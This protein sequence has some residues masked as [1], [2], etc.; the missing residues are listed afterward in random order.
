MSAVADRHRPEAGR[1]A[2]AAGGL[3]FPFGERRPDAGTAM[4]V[5]PGVHWLR[6]PLPFR[7]DHINLWLLEDGDG[8]TLVDTG[9]QLDET[10]QHWRTLFDRFGIAHGGRPGRPATR[11]IVTHFHPD[12]IGLAGWLVG[13]LDTELWITRTE[14]LMARMLWL[15]SDAASHRSMADFYTRHGLAPDLADRLFAG[16]NTYRRRVA[17]TPVRHRRLR[18][19]DVLEIGGRRWEV[20]V[21][22][23]HAPEHACLWTVDGN[24][25]ISGDQILPGIT[26]NI[27]V[28]PNEPDASPL[29]DYLGSFARF[30]RLPD[31][32]L[33]LPSH[34][35]PF[36]GLQTRIGQI[37]DHHRERLERLAGAFEGERLSAADAV[38]LL[39]RRDLDTHQ[40]GFAL[41]EC[42]A[43]LAWLEGAGTLAGRLDPDGI[44][45]FE[46]C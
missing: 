37:V 25:L 44:H 6:M 5:A 27:S 13:E 40:M 20:I 9:M 23:G 39:F 7:L 43:H 31:D 19:G 11:L 41:G 18:A 17:E 32:A 3:E 46:R 29:E 2:G 4:E 16:G 8:W 10:R 36:R 26:P 1:G 38:P 35:L 34:N 45:R 22:T 28:W 15:D 30:G 21:G 24:M 12:H 14:W 42:L 33:V